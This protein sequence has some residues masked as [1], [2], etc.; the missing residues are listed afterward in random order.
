VQRAWSPVVH[1]EA[2]RELVSGLPDDPRAIEAADQEVAWPNDPL[3]I[4]A[5]FLDRGW[6]DPA[7]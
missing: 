4:R 6:I 2:V 5:C 1:S 7:D 3:P